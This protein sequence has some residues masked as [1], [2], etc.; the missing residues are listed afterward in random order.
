MHLLTL[1]SKNVAWKNLLVFT[2]EEDSNVRASAVSALGHAFAYINDKD[3][4][5]KDLVTIAK[6]ETNL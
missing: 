5:W 1:I 4:A 3:K 6:D 2:K